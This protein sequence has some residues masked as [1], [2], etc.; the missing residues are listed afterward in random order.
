[1]PC[2]HPVIGLLTEAALTMLPLALCF[3]EKRC[4]EDKEAATLPITWVFLLRGSLK[5]CI[6]TDSPVNKDWLHSA[7][8]S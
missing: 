2:T 4:P 7:Q 8:S 1:M 3:L 5:L 6:E